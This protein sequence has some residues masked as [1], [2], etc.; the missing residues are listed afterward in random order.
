MIA[1][2]TLD[3][4]AADPG[5]GRGLPRPT[6]L[7]LSAR[8]LAAQTAILAALLAQPSEAAREE[9]LLTIRE[10]ADRLGRTVDWIKRHQHELPFAIRESG[11]HPRFSL[12]G[13]L[14]WAEEAQQ[15]ARGVR[16]PAGRSADG[17]SGVA[18]RRQPRVT[19]A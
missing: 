6:L 12:L 15:G 4:L 19:T 3:E 13:F 9:R 16:S 10:L 17:V 2:P 14:K 11:A 18:L 8:A 5:K 1:V 7:G